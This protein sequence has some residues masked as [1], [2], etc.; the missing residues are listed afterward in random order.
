M[1][2]LYA[3]FERGPRK[4]LVHSGC[5]DAELM[6]H[7]CNTGRAPFARCH[8]SGPSSAP[9]STIAALV[10]ESGT[11]GVDNVSSTLAA[12]MGSLS[13][14]KLSR[15]LFKNAA[16]S[17]R[18]GNKDLQLKEDDVKV[19]ASLP[20]LQTFDFARE[21]SDHGWLQ[22]SLEVLFGI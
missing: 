7:V 12:S 11:L 8:E 10:G 22:E 18:L 5:Q 20:R 9:R 21:E 19:L 15:I 6:Y 2:M 14:L 1:N 4:M 3:A 13:K 16:R 17:G